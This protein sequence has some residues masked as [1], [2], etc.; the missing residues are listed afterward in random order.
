M[1]EKTGTLLLISH[2]DYVSTEL[3]IQRY[4]QDRTILLGESKKGDYKIPKKT[5]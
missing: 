4:S 5:W 3:T 1:F 2:N